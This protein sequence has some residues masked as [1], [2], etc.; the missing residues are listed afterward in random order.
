M[1]KIASL[2]YDVVV[3]KGFHINKGL[4]K[5]ELNK[6]KLNGRKHSNRTNSKTIQSS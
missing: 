4:D 2:Y 5:S 1:R 6:Y 3:R